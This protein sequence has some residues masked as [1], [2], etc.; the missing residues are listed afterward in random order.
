MVLE[1]AFNRFECVEKW[2]LEGCQRV[3]SVPVNS[4]LT[5]GGRGEVA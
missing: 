3:S 5:G 2:E 1:G 4:V